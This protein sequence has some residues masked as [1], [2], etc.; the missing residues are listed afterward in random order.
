VISP[1]GARPKSTAGA[2]PPS[3]VPPSR[4]QRA[5]RTRDPRGWYCTPCAVNAQLA[6]RSF[7][8]ATIWPPHRIATAAPHRHRRETDGARA[9]PQMGWVYVGAYHQRH[10]RIGGAR[11]KH[12]QP[13]RRDV[14]AHHDGE[15]HLQQRPP[16][17]AEAVRRWG[18]RSVHDGAV[19]A[20]PLLPEGRRRLS[21]PLLQR[22]GLHPPLLPRRRLRRRLPPLLRPARERDGVVGEQRCQEGVA[23]LH[24]ARPL[25]LV[26]RERGR[27]SLELETAELVGLHRPRPGGRP[28]WDARHLRRLPRH[29]GR[30]VPLG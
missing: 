25:P 3:P 11:S 5:S 16:D 7:R 21:A 24:V 9:A 6:R 14:R 13:P 27:R 19:A 28:P 4:I 23:A 1:A 18:C 8:P 29:L 12:P 17:E 30:A 15:A 10:R 20:F 26:A 2:P 22:L